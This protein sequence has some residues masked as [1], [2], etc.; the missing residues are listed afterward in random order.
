[1][2]EVGCGT[3]QTLNMTCDTVGFDI[4]PAALNIAK[5]NCDHPV[6]GDIFHIPFKDNTFDLT[7][8]SGVIEHFP[9]PFNKK[10]IREMVRITKTGGTVIVIV[11]NSLMSLV[12]SREVCCTDGSESSSSDTR[13]IICHRG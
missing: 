2:I 9:D 12:S 5:Y 4:S 10:A 13:R 11:P 8:N 6:Q 7:Y 3:G 1:M